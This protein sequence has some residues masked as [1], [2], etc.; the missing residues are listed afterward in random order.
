MGSWD[1]VRLDTA[2]TNLL[3]NAFKFGAGKPVRVSVVRVGQTACVSVRDEG[4]GIDQDQQTTLFQKF[5][6]AV[7]ITSFGGFG[8]GLWI[9]DQLVRAHGGQVRLQSRAGQGATFSVELPL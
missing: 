5:G 9:V 6:R 3:D 1:A 2:I 7:P 8:L 4:I